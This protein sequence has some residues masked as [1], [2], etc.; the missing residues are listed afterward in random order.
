LTYKQFIILS[1]LI[2]QHF[3]AY[4][5]KQD[6]IYHETPIR[7]GRWIA[8]LHGVINSGTIIRPDSTLSNKKF[9]NNY[10]FSVSGY[11]VIIDRMALGLLFTI[12]RTGTEEF[13]IRESESFNVG[14]SFR[15]Y[16]ATQKQ[17]GPYV[18]TSAIYSRFYD[19]IAILDIQNPV[20]RVLK[21]SGPGIMLGLGYG[22]VFKD[23]LSLEI[24]FDFTHAWLSGETVDQI[25]NTSTGTDF[26][27][28][29]FSFSF[30]LG[31]LIGKQK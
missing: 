26:R 29:S 3:L 12:N 30:G 21:G 7:K 24:G 25:S 18:L 10:A 14:P 23:I 27:R 28:F 15:Y 16:L 22:Y 17:G 5:Q 20:D 9:S 2:V 11:K 1:I 19:R 13:F 6:S 8:V 4:G 31:I